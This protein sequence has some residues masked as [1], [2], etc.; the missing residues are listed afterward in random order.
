MSNGARVQAYNQSNY[1]VV[2]DIRSNVNRLKMLLKDLD[3][4]D[5]TAV[6]VISLRAYF[7]G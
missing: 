3:D 5:Q 1:L 2:S 6:E 4:P 7:C